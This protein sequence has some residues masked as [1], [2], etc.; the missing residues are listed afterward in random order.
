MTGLAISNLRV[1]YHSARSSSTQLQWKYRASVNCTIQFNSSLARLDT[2][3]GHRFELDKAADS[4]ALLIF[5]DFS[6]PATVR[7]CLS[8]CC[9]FLPNEKC[10]GPSMAPNLHP[11]SE[12]SW[13]RIWCRFSQ[14]QHIYGKQRTSRPSGCTVKGA[15]WHVG[16]GVVKAHGWGFTK[17]AMSWAVR[18]EEQCVMECL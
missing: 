3:R 12:A 14:R 18:M 2:L 16:D 10:S 9:H 1:L 8:S 5:S 11:S 4:V 15:P 7:P 17:A 13:W 6:Y